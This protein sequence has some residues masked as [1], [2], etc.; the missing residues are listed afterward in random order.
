MDNL[1]KVFRAAGWENRVFQPSRGVRRSDVT[2]VPRIP[3]IGRLINGIEPY[4][5]NLFLR[6]GPLARLA[7]ADV[8]ISHYAFHAPP[9]AALARKTIILSHGVEWHLEKMTWDDREHEK[10]ARW[11]RDRFVHV[12]N[13]THY[14]RHLDIPV[15]AGQG[16]FQEVAPGKWFV[17]NCVDSQ[18]FRRT[19]GLPE[20]LASPRVL[21]PRQVCEDR[22][23]HLAIRAFRLI[24]DVVPE[25]TL[26]ILGKIRPG[27]YIGFCRD[28]IR[29]LGLSAKVIFQDHV[30]NGTMVDY[31]SSS[32]VTL[33]P[34]LRREGTS[35]SALESMACGTATVST[36]V[37][38]LRDLPTT[39]CEPTEESVAAAILRTYPIRES[40]GT[41]QSKI[42]RDTF[43]LENW[44]AAWKQVVSTVTAGEDRR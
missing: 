2:T 10:R 40:V 36:N 30:E 26:H 38:G 12:V 24:V 29:S 27:P 28:L 9:L 18:V 1:S 37:A 20:L 15:P 7:E 8:I 44:A 22:G 4:L 34:T 25:L 21:V 32:A 11:A 13:D 5:F 16:F 43:N 3:K 33:I 19:K 42:V 39:Q 17:P 14:L 6:F 35:L 31:Y 23:I 41:E